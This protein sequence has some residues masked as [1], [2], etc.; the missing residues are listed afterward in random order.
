MG[1]N[2]RMV[3]L[4]I[5]RHLGKYTDNTTKLW[6]DDLKIMKSKALEM[7]LQNFKLFTGVC[8]NRSITILAQHQRNELW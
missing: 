3:Y 2:V 7:L 5:I 1:P 4:V 6:I 8:M